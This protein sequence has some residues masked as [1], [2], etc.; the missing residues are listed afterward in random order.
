VIAA[1]DRYDLN[2]SDAERWFST[3][4]MRSVHALN[5][6]L[7]NLLAAELLRPTTDNR[8]QLALQLREAIARLDTEAQGRAAQ[9][10]IALIDA[11]FRNDAR[12]AKAIS[13]EVASTDEGSSRG[14][15]PNLSATRLAQMTLTLAS[16]AAQ[17]SIERAC[18]IFAMSPACA[19]IVG[20]LSLPA[21]EGIAER[22][23]DWIRP[24]WEHRPDLWR[25]LLELAERPP[26]NAAPS[27]GLRAMQLQL[28]EL[29]LA[30][31]ICA[32]TRQ[33]RR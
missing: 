33:I 25:A 32:A 2:T 4:A 15:F 11:G 14:N 17:L 27:I 21:I 8:L 9:C 19:Q 18:L 29:A 23:A 30:T 28:G 5:A 1:P 7:L 22:H 6:Y 20:T 12:W 31:P 10:P 24:R 3:E 26:P 13:G 16:M